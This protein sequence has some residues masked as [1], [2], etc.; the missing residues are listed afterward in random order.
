VDAAVSY[1]SGTRACRERSA[2]LLNGVGLV[3]ADG[4]E[5]VPR[6]VHGHHDVDVTR[7]DRDVARAGI[8]L[9]GG[10]ELAAVRAEAEPPLHPDDGGDLP[11]V[12]PE[13]HPRHRR[14]FERH[15]GLAEDP[16]DE[17]RAPGFVAVVD[18]LVA[19]ETTPGFFPGTALELPTGHLDDSVEIA[20]RY[21]TVV[22]GATALAVVTVGTADAQA[23]RI[24]PLTEVMAEVIGAASGQ[25]GVAVLAGDTTFG[26]VGIQQ[27]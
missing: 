8:L 23:M 25:P 14:R 20:V 17:V 27:G 7:V 13:V 12:A 6:W 24:A 1:E 11:V 10:E 15:A 18:V 26:Q 9:V 21:V 3:T 2:G 5:H 22:P 16:A 19:D 4:D